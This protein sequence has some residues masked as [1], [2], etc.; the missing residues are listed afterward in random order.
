MFDASDCQP[1]IGYRRLSYD[2]NISANHSSECEGCVQ[3]E[4]SI[5][6]MIIRSL[7]TG[8]HDGDTSHN[9]VLSEF[10]KVVVNTELRDRFTADTWSVWG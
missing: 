2:L 6:M 10:W 8:D 1:E 4:A 3:S 5:L 9:W 7:V